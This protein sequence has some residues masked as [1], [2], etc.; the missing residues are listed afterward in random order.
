MSPIAA[1]FIQLLSSA[2]EPWSL[3]RNHHL[4]TLGED[5]VLVRNSYVGLNPFDWKG[6]KHRF[7]LK[8]L[9]SVLGR[10]GSGIIVS[11][12]PAVRRLKRGDKVRPSI[13]L[14]DHSTDVKIW[15]CANSALPNSGA[16]QEYSVHKG[17]EV[18]SLPP[19]M[20]LRSGA[21]LG[22]GLLTA[23]IILFK[24][25]RLS[26]D[27]LSYKTEIRLGGPWIL[28]VTKGSTHSR[29]ASCRALEALGSISFSFR[30]FS[31]FASYALPQSRTTKH[32]KDSAQISYWIGTT[33]SS[34]WSSESGM[35][36][37][38]RLVESITPR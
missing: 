18:G 28:Y 3:H 22:T 37:T 16:F 38:E 13:L 8:D 31:D 14:P 30:D 6:A 34:R 20:S 17:D 26:I 7:S 33:Q 5:E 21:T 32:S 11:V 12:G 4:P 2:S 36:R 29:Q 19:D 23:A 25:F 15:F 1:G 24:C 35:S 9:P 10:D 27:R